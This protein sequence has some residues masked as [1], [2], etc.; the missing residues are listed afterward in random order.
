MECNYEIGKIYDS[1]F[2]GAMYFHGNIVLEKIDNF[3]LDHS[4]IETIFNEMKP[5]VPT[6][7]SILSPIFLP[8][9]NGMCALTSFFHEQIDFSH[10]TID[11]FLCK[12]AAQSSLLRAKIA[13]FLF[14]DMPSNVAQNMGPDSFMNLL[15]A[16]E[17][18]QEFK[19]H[20][21][22]LFG[23]FEYAINLLITYLRM[24]YIQ[25]DLLHQ[26]ESATISSVLDRAHSKQNEELYNRCCMASFSM[27][28]KNDSST[29]LSISLLN[30]YL[31]YVA[32]ESQQ[33][34][35]I[36]GSQNE[37]G[38]RFQAE[39][40]II[41]LT[42]VLLALGHPT[43]L[44]I[45]NTYR[46]FG[47]LTAATVSKQLQMPPVTIVRHISILC[48]SAILNVSRR[49]GIQIF[50]KLNYNILETAIKVAN[51]YLKGSTHYEKCEEQ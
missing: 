42:Q 33:Y 24:I 41:D 31:Y 34:R 44:A 8:R 38:A 46:E 40:P 49:E 14:S 2:Y 45:I 5:R 11:S 15:L 25:V 48:E 19:L 27:E 43:R 26:K 29:I 32:L 1:I 3:F 7:P 18:S 30:P 35:C 21:S 28:F 4:K 23:Q 13:T 9:L 39:E 51:K 47:E 10:E 6:L 22:L 20:T 50:Y 37:K 16:S 17:Y 12:I 36:I